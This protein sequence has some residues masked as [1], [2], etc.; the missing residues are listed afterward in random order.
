MMPVVWRYAAIEATCRE[1]DPAEA[2][3]APRERP[4]YAG[5]SDR[6]RRA[7][8]LAGRI[9]AKRLLS[10]RFAGEMLS[11]ARIEIDSGDG[12]RQRARPRVLLDG[13]PLPGRLSI[14]H[15]GHTLL[16]ALVDGDRL[17][18]GVDLLSP[19]DCGRGFAE[20]WFT[21]RERRWLAE[22]R[23]LWPVAW[24]IKEAAYKASNQG[25]AFRP[26]AFEVLPHPAGGFSCLLR[27]CRPVTLHRLSVWRTA[28]DETAILA[29]YDGDN[30]D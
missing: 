30:H 4:V 5:L 26:R 2:W 15:S 19:V 12:R 9:V 8:W 11:P 20:L 3:L 10:E 24:A 28:G 1:A 27:D 17:S 7:E 14:A 21:P 16:V 25:E 22:D 6:R 29:L 18:V 23:R 13:R